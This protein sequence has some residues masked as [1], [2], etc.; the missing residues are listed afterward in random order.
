MRIY[1]WYAESKDIHT[2]RRQRG[3]E[4]EREIEQLKPRWAPVDALNYDMQAQGLRRLRFEQPHK[5]SEVRA[6]FLS[7]SVLLP[8]LSFKAWNSHQHNKI[9]AG[10]SCTAS[11][12]SDA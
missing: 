10:H 6:T 7:P 12:D 11:P 3:R 2:S 5:E 9:C 8:T 4:R 1:R